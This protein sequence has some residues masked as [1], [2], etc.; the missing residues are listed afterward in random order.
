MAG[1]ERGRDGLRWLDRTIGIPAVAALSTLKRRKPFPSEI[2][3]IGLIALGAI[4][5][6]IISVGSAIPMLRQAFPDAKLHLFT[7]KANRGI[8]PLLAPV[9]QVHVI[10]VTDP[11]QAV[12]LL[13][14]TKLDVLLDFGPWPRI[15]AMLAALSNA[16][17][18]VG[19]K[20]DGQ[21]RHYAFDL[22]VKHSAEIHEFDNHAALLAS[23]G[24]PRPAWPKITPSAAARR[25][26]RD[27]RS[28]PYI[29]CHPWASGFKSEMREWPIR[30]WQELAAIVVERGWEVVFTGGPSDVAKS[31]MLFEGIAANDGKVQ[32]AAGR[33]SLD[34]TAALLEGC[35]SVVTV[36]TGVLHLAA[37]VSASIVALHG[38][39]NPARWGPLS[40]NAAVLLPDSPDVAYLNLGFEY[41]KDA[42]PC[43]HLLDVGRVAASL[44]G[45][46][47]R[48]QGKR[49]FGLSS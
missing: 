40:G 23:I 15:S 21:Y 39:T 6:T 43:M 31:R 5:D 30:Y 9:D 26:I 19:F 16:G 45:Q 12:S 1:V 4:G 48:A 8:A 42:K 28:K 47:Q 13:R 14:S 25:K 3:S 7:S 37:A 46:L 32:D 10:A 34:E 33:Y 18:T 20:T 27:D 17:F 2:S 41:P 35:D 24:V 11:M 22:A 38:P 36:N 44:L 49:A 29:V